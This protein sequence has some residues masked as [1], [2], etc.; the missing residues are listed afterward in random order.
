MRAERGGYLGRRA[1]AVLAFFVAAFFVAAFFVAAFEVFTA[2]L[3]APF[4][5]HPFALVVAERAERADLRR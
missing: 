1:F 3:F 5:T 2:P 4:F